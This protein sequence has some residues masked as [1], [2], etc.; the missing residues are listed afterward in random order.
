VP[1]NHTED[2]ASKESYAVME[3][4]GQYGQP[5]NSLMPAG[6]VQ[7]AGIRKGVHPM[8]ALV[9]LTDVSKT[10]DGDGPPA[11]AHVSM[12][13][14]RGESVAIMGPSGSGKST[15]LNLIAGLDRPTSG[16]TSCPTS[17]S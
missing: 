10:Y 13:V 6:K 2:R 15:L 1:W 14:S 11:V 4:P 8:E 17:A 16:A 5:G 3:K 12:Q 9:Q 7:R